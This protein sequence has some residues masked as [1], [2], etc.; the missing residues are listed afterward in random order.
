[1]QVWRSQPTAVWRRACGA[2]A[3]EPGCLR[4]GF[5]WS[6]TLPSFLSPP[7]Q[8]RR[9]IA[10]SPAGQLQPTNSLFNCAHP[11]RR[12]LVAVAHLLRWSLHTLLSLLVACSCRR[13]HI[14]QT[15]ASSL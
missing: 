2:G 15:V 8:G 13:S 6:C 7:P 1:M 9:I 5:G 11:P 14:L 4:M 10:H 12:R 3:K